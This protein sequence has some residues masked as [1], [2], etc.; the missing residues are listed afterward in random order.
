MFIKNSY[1][2]KSSLSI[3]ITVNKMIGYFKWLVEQEPHGK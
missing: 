2:E 1:K 3:T